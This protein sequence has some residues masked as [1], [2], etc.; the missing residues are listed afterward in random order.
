M[1]RPTCTSEAGF[2]AARHSAPADGA[3]ARGILGDAIAHGALE[4]VREASLRPAAGR[5][6]GR[7]RQGLALARRVRERGEDGVASHAVGHRVVQ[8][9]EDR[10]ARFAPVDLD[11]LPERPGA[12]ERPLVDRADGVEEPILVARRGRLL[13]QRVAAHVKVEVE[14][15]IF[16]PAREREPE[17]RL[18]HALSQPRNRLDHARHRRAQPLR[19]GPPVEQQQQRHRGALAR[20]V[21]VP[22]GQVFRRERSRF[23]GVQARVLR[24]SEHTPEA[25][26][27]AGRGSCTG[28]RFA[29]RGRWYPSRVHWRFE[30]R[31]VAAVKR[32]LAAASLAGSLVAISVHAHDSFDEALAQVDLAL[33]IA[34]RD[35]ELWRRRAALT[36]GDGDLERSRA[37]L[38]RA[39]AL[40]LPPAL[41]ERERGALARSENEFVDAERHLRR[42]RE[43]APH[44]AETLVAHAETLA[45]LGRW[46]EA[47]DAY[48]HGIEHAP[49]AGPD[50]HLARVRALAAGEDAN[51]FEALRA[52]DEAIAKLGPIPALAQEGIALELRAHRTD[53]ALA[54]LSRLSAPARRGADWR[55]QRAEILEDAGRRQQAA[56]EYAAALASLESLPA[57]R[58]STPAAVALDARARDGLE[59]LGALG[60]E[61]S[62]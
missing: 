5:L 14:G 22:E 48:A 10:G 23:E 50:L 25:S 3:R 20:L 21:G 24:R 52:V 47:A 8:A 27:A 43:L 39:C 11:H 42:A 46:R 2:F 13:G 29:S 18:H 33:A 56:E 58:R 35:A 59:R 53:A 32:L 62:R 1:I 36:R 60:R 44:D 30:A 17:G 26:A 6:L 9:E 40:G 19:I 41:A 28:L 12:V 37:D 31:E 57:A 15:R 34:P 55:V 7:R 4:D 49:A 16:L 54:R 45:S 61:R 51:P 38:A